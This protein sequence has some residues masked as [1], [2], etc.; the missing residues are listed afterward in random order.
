MQGKHSGVGSSA[1]QGKHN[2]VGSSAVQGRHRGVGSSCGVDVPD[3]AA[4]VNVRNSVANNFFI[5]FSWDR[6]LR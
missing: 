4:N 3:I 1:V 6:R 2:G 5:K